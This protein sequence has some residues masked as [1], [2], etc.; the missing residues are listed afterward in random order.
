[1][2][3]RVTEGEIKRMI[4]ESV[5]RLL[6]FD[7]SFMGGFDEGFSG[8]FDETAKKRP[9]PPERS[10]EDRDGDGDTSNT[11]MERKRN[12]VLDMFSNDD[13]KSN[14]KRR[15]AIELLYHPKDDGEWDTYRSEFSKYLDPDD[16]AHVWKD[17]QINKLYNWLSDIL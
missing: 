13:E 14:V 3:I 15:G 17:S 8:G 10:P 4:A 6:E 7:E 9:A 11:D 16:T 12:V 5:N 2:I 1:M